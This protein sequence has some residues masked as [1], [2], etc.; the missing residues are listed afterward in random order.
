[1]LSLPIGPHLSESQ[2]QQVID[3]LRDLV[4]T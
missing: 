2:Q 4:A 1:V 3:A